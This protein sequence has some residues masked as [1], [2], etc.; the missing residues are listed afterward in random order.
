MTRFGAKL[1]TCSSNPGP[2]MD[3]LGAGGR[4]WP[5]AIREAVGPS[6]LSGR[7]LGGYDLE[8]LIGVGGMGEVYRARDGKLGRDVAIKVLPAA[9]TADPGRLARFEREAR[10]LAALNH[11]NVCAIYGFEESEGIRFLILELVEGETLADKLGRLAAK[12]RTA[13]GLSQREALN[14]ARQIARALDVAH[15]RGIV[16]RDLKP[17]NIKITN[18]DVVKVLDFGLA[19][20]VTGDGPDI[21]AG[22]AETATMGGTMDGAIVGTPAYMSPEQARGH[23]VDKR[24]DIWAFGCVL[25][26][27]LTGRA[28]FGGDTLSDTIAS[29]LERE[30]DWSR[31]PADTPEPIRNL[32]VGCL[33]KDPRDRL[34]DIGDVRISIDSTLSGSSG[35]RTVAREQRPARRVPFWLPWVLTAG[36]G[37]G[38]AGLVIWAVRPP[39]SAPAPPPTASNDHRYLFE[40]LA[41]SQLDRSGGGHLIAISRD[42]TKML[43]VATPDR[44]YVRPMAEVDG[45]AV[46]GTEVHKGVR[47]A[48]FSPTG[49]SIVFYAF[50]ERALYR[51]PVVGGQASMIVETETPFGISWPV[52]DTILFGQGRNGIWRATPNGVAS[53]VFTVEAGQEAHGPQLLPDRDHVLYTIASG[54][55]RERWDTSEIMVGS[56]TTKLTTRLGITGSDARYIAETGHLVYAVGTKLFAAPFDIDRLTAGMGLPVGIDDVSRAGGAYTGAANFSVSDNGTLIY[57]P[58]APLGLMALAFFRPDGTFEKQL[59]LRPGRYVRPRASPKGQ[60]VAFTD[61]ADKPPRIYTYDE[62]QTGPPSRVRVRQ[63]SRL[64]VERDADRVSSG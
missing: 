10:A 8:A 12:R 26:E 25:Y 44:L 54:D 19:K 24:T 41:G 35:S 14:I 2:T 30:P 47:E 62:G 53:Q 29:V 43:Y 60:R 64:G 9:F 32:L 39:S 56:L 16:H 33:A 13:G 51:I 22:V 42:G 5:S 23:A 49:Q 27:M 48:A 17:A 46:P 40:L 7:S 21:R 58:G 63:V 6:V 37:A 36:L 28:A 20:A 15:E 50:A 4:R 11:P 18:G 57:V 34:R 1:K 59:A 38:L 52:E 55:S 31:L 3:S 45:T 61:D